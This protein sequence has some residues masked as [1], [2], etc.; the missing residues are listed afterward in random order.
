MYDDKF[1]PDATRKLTEELGDADVAKRLMPFIN[2]AIFTRSPEYIS[3]YEADTIIGLAFGNIPPVSG[4]PND[5]AEPGQ[6]NSELALCCA[7]LYRKKKMPMY[8]QWEIARFFQQ[9]NFPDIS[10]KD[11]H[12]IE[13]IRNADGSLI[14]LSTEGVVQAIINDHFCGKAHSVGKAATIGHRD[15]VKR[16]VMTCRK[17]DID[18]CAPEGIFLP[19]WYDK[20]SGQAWTR[21]RDL[22]VL[23]DMSVQLMALAQQNIDV[24]SAK[25]QNCSVKA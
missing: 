21:S 20:N 5:L 11:V 18:A 24:A 25:E 19:A 15:H 16:C 2:D 22:Y 17:L 10:L 9:G 4:N 6:M 7:Q 12:S 14:Y 1:L 13:P 3:P 8:L 23:Q